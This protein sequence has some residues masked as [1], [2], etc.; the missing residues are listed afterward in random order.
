MA[1]EKIL[2]AIGNPIRIKIL[3]MLAE[4]REVGVKE[5]K[6]ILGISTGSLYYHLDTL[7]DL[8]ERKRGFIRIS[9]KGKLVLEELHDI[10]EIGAIKDTLLANPIVYSISTIISAI[11]LY[12]YYLA[13][14][15]NNVSLLL[16]LIPCKIGLPLE[17][18]VLLLVALILLASIVVTRRFSFNYLLLVPY[19]ISA[20]IAYLPYLAYCH[21]IN[22]AYLLFSLSFFIIFASISISKVVGI[23]IEKAAAIVLSIIYVGL[24][25]CLLKG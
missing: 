19:T 24:M 5:L 9:S 3:K 11:V 18:E 15:T 23:R 12:S 10:E 17:A 16:G 21:V 7:G 8:I 20:L 2:E 22:K 1:S 13:Y 4:R 25:V 14:R 6:E